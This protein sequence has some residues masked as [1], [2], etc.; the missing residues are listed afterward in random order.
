[1]KLSSRQTDAVSALLD[2]YAE[3]RH[4]PIAYAR[5]AE[6]VGVSPTTA[7]RMLRLAEQLGYVRVTH[8]A[9]RTKSAVGRSPVLFEPTESAHAM[10][11]P[12]AS[13]ES[14]EPGWEATRRRVL[15]A[16]ASEGDD[17]LTRAADVVLAS[18]DEPG[19][20]AD[21]AG[22]MIAALMLTVEGSTA[23]DANGQVTDLIARPATRF[24]ISTLG[25][26]LLGLALADRASRS[27]TDRLQRGLGRFHAALGE[28]TSDDSAAITAFAAQLH[29][30]IE[31]RNRRTGS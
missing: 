28:L 13:G 30:A 19:T 31:A 17:A 26:M 3:S 7:Y 27:L 4:E 23:L 29:V 1:M 11:G 8:G 21:T 14:A 18:L 25:G 24:S 16:L 15:E 5:V 20:P 6:R 10:V 12:F 2:L 22:R 9:R